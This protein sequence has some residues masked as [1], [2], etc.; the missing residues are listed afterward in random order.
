MLV[1]FIDLPTFFWEGVVGGGGGVA[2]ADWIFFYRHVDFFP[3]ITR[4]TPEHK[5][6]LND[7]RIFLL[8]NPLPEGPKKH[9]AKAQAL[10]VT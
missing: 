8:K 1:N 6:T 10:L 3:K 7:L 4:V 9:Q 5:N 2:R